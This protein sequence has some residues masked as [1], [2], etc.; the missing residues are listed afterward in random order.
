MQLAEHKQLNLFGQ[1]MDGKVF[2]FSDTHL[3]V[4]PMQ[5]EL[6]PGQRAWT[7]IH[8]HRQRSLEVAALLPKGTQQ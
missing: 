1:D 2:W 5:M 8:G 3:P 6:G 4:Q 7:R